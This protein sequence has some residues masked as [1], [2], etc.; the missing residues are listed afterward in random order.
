MFSVS[1]INTFVCFLILKLIL[2]DLN[3]SCATISLKNPT[4]N[5]FLL[6]FTVLSMYTSRWL[7]H[8]GLLSIKLFNVLLCSF[9]SKN[10]YILG[11]NVQCMF[12]IQISC[13][14]FINKISKVLFC[15]MIYQATNVNNKFG[16]KVCWTRL[17]GV[18]KVWK[19]FF[20]IVKVLHCK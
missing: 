3:L 5:L 10:M 17:F 7:I 18:P 14:S 9:T 4:T 8:C 11:K 6:V 15:C 16:H 2:I 13:L 1:H 12:W 19:E 20:L